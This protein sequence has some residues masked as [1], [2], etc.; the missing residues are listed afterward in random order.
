MRSSSSSRSACRQLAWLAGGAVV[1]SLLLFLSLRVA[2]ADTLRL[3]GLSGG[4]LSESELAQRDTV[5]VIWAS[6]SPRCRDIAARVN[7]LEKQWG[8]RARIMTVNFQEEEGDV[9]AFLNATPLDVAVYLDERGE[10]AKKH[11]ITYL[12]GL[13]VYRQGTL[14]YKGRY[15][16][17]IDSVLSETLR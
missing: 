11:S 1:L 10:F 8:E 13:L 4:E 12:P 3:R 9:R 16:E 17:D 7:R 6:W 15:P 2:A 14:R 5:I